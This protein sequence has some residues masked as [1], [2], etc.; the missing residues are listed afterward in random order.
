MTDMTKWLEEFDKKFHL[1]NYELDCDSHS[2]HLNLDCLKAFFTRAMKEYAVSQLN[3]IRIDEEDFD[4]DN[5]GDAQMMQGYYERKR[6]AIIK[7][8]QV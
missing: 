3:K 1:R 2:P 5:W 6:D 4:D 8:N 7:D